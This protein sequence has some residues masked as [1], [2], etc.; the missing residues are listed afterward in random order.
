MKETHLA[1]DEM[2]KKV[3][4]LYKMMSHNVLT[5]K[6]APNEELLQYFLLHEWS[7]FLVDPQ[8]KKIRP[9]MAFMKRPLT[10]LEFITF[11]NKYDDIAD[12]QLEKGSIL[13]STS[14]ATVKEYMNAREKIWAI[15]KNLRIMAEDLYLYALT[16]LHI[17]VHI[18][19]SRALL[20]KRGEADLPAF[21]KN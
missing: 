4:K 7:T 21:G 12:S 14:P 20:K 10:E 3:R 5:D 17:P 6:S 11:L 19:Q 9:H 15:E 1:I 2:V 13:D 8:I 18:E 16:N